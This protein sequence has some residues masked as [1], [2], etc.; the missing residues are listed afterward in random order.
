MDAKFTPGPWSLWGKADPSQVIACDGG[1][2]AQ[3]VG[4]N[5]EANARLIA[6]APELLEAVEAAIQCIGELS[7]TQARVEV[8]QMLQ[9]AVAKAGA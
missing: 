6:A 1:F 3:T 2:V 8:M 5:D 7:P 9:A 4:G